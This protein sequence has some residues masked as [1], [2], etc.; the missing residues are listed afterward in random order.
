MM[1]TLKP[2]SDSTTDEIPVKGGLFAIGRSSTPFNQLPKEQ[3]IQLSRRHARIFEEQGKLYI[4]DLG[5]SNGT[6]LN[7]RSLADQ[8]ELLKH[9]DEIMFGNL[10]Y[11][12]QDDSPQPQP[13]P[14]E[15]CPFQLTLKPQSAKI[16]E[17]LKTAAILVTDFPCLLSKSSG[18]IAEYCQRFDV[19]PKFLSRRHA[20]IFINDQQ[21]WLE[22][23]GS[24]NGSL[25]NGVAL[26]EQAQAIKDGDTLQ[27]GQSEEM[28][29]A[30]R[31]L[32]PDQDDTEF[33]GGT[34]QTAS[35]ILASKEHS[36]EPNSPSMA[37]EQSIAPGTIL[38]DKANTFLD[39]FCDN[40]EDDKDNGA[41]DDSV[42]NPSISKEKKS[43]QQNWFT[44][45]FRSDPD[46]EPSLLST[47]NKFILLIAGIGI[48]SFSSY[49]YI[50]NTAENRINKLYDNERYEDAAILANQ[51]LI[52]DPDN[53]A[54]HNL[55][56]Q[57]GIMWLN[58]YWF[59]PFKEQNY[60][61]ANMHLQY[62][63]KSLTANPELTQL[64]TLLIWVTELEELISNMRDAR[65][66]EIYGNEEQ[67]RSLISRWEN[68]PQA[69][70]HYLGLIALHIPDFSTAQ[71][72]VLSHLRELKN[73]QSIYLNAIDRL[74]A[75]IKQILKQGDLEKLSKQLSNFSRKYPNIR[76]IKSLEQ[77]LALYRRMLQKKD[78]K[79]LLELVS[80][81]TNETFLSPP[82]EQEAIFQIDEQLP[83]ATV[84]EQYALA[85]RAWREGDLVDAIR[86]AGA[87]TK[88]PWGEVASQWLD[89]YDNI[90][91]AYEHLLEQRDTQNYQSLL[92][93]FHAS[94][95]PEKDQYFLEQL[96]AE[97]IPIRQ[98]VLAEAKEDFQKA[99]I[100][101]QRYHQ[102]GGI[103]GIMRLEATTGQQF[104]D[105]SGELGSAY[106]LALEARKKAAY[107]DKQSQTS[108]H[109]LFDRI[110]T[111]IA[112][113]RSG[114][115]D[116]RSVL[117]DTLVNEKLA[118]LPVT[119]AEP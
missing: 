36:N 14:T 104:R 4:V 28:I 63:S 111:E 39:I 51:S 116:L 61:D 21:L 52:S 70:Q 3:S 87:L 53:E 108:N 77:D 10:C 93:A 69:N 88:E 66:V 9:N 64:I 95:Q 41:D 43:T 15:V 6:F 100:I 91:L 34:S 12:I 17:S 30:L 16:K 13:R 31:I 72:T 32:S 67:I 119:T 24:T 73:T 25:L 98:Q 113:Q 110:S 74:K 19:D 92:L 82:F 55:S 76:G 2:L 78:D 29:F 27:L 112:H 102:H 54:L 48:I 118:L 18:V 37:E 96:E 22:D 11:Q 80:L 106:Q 20:H 38:L 107:F 115:E 75:T 42:E 57:S 50:T 23:M 97:I 35:Q 65:D 71:T 47:R 7:G 81:R 109:T 33:L 26:N 105:R 68:K 1:I 58:H 79:Q 59:K 101:W 89:H 99:E 114:L 8:P 103:K 56:I 86:I 62:A 44:E 40:K 49:F 45:F 83:P 94:L 90:L 85:D 60:T 84:I 46:E 117:G 5:S